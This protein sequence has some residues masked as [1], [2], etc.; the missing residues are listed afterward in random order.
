MKAVVCTKY[1]TPDVLQV[2]DREKPA[3]ETNTVLVKVAA[4][5]VTAGDYRVRGLNVPAGLGVIMKLAMGFSKPRNDVLGSEF[6]GVVESVGSAVTK[7]QPGDSVFGMTGVQ[8]GANAEYLALKENGP[9]WK[10][11]ELLSF[12]EAA[13]IPFGATT[14]L[15]FLRDLGKIESGQKVLIYGASSG[16]GVAAVQIAKAFGAEVTA[17]CSGK[18]HPL[19]EELGADHSIDYTKEDFTTKGEQYDIVLEV[20]G[21]VHSTHCL[22][23]VKKGGTL[24]L[25]SG[26]LPQYFLMPW[27]NLFTGKRVKAGVTPERQEDIQVIADMVL[28]GEL[29]AVIDSTYPLEKTAEAHAFAEKGHK[30]G[31]VVLEI[32]SSL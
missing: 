7:F 20:V 24:L 6:S 19:M 31:S 21:K 8:L 15:F 11:P 17:V 4:S 3:V 22:K 23:A 16:V 32:D 18:N 14:A 13:A 26:D 29:K 28:A 5:S 27:Q 2:M 25:V 10:K 9:L 12:N 1:G 30:V